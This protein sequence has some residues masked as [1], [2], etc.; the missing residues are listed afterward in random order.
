LLLAAGE[1]ANLAALESQLAAS[2]AE[3]AKLTIA[4]ALAK[5]GRTDEEAV[6]YYEQVYAESSTP[7]G[8]GDDRIAAALYE[9]LRDLHG[10]PILELRR[11][12]RNE[13]GS[14][15]FNSNASGDIFTVP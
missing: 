2:H 7:A 3:L 14:R 6:K 12:M 9:I 10:Q 8:G 15:L 11:R 5:A 4:A 13:K 1:H